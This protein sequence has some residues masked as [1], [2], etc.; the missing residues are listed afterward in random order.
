MHPLEQ[1]IYRIIVDQKLFDRD[2]RLVVG[3]SGGPDSMALLYL[4]DALR[5][6][7]PCFPVAVYVDHGLRPGETPAESQVV[8]QAAGI[9]DLP[10]EAVCVDTEK[11]ARERGL[12]LEHAARELRYESLAEVADRYRA[13]C[14]V[15]AHT[16][17][18]QVEEVLIRLLRGSG[19]CGLSGMRMRR[20]RIIRPL[21]MTPKAELLHYLQDRN[22]SFCQDSSNLDRRF[23]RNRIRLDLLPLLERE[24]D[25]GVRKALLKTAEN[26]AEDEAFLDGQTESVWQQLVRRADPVQDDGEPGYLLERSGFCLLHSALQRRLAE[27]LL[28][29]LGARPRYEHI[30]MVLTA[31]RQGVTGSELHL[32]Q[33]LRVEVKRDLLVFSY[34]RGRG[35]WRGR[36]SS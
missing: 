21:L 34:P 30:I 28:W 32:S 7:F 15:V 18:D 22:I 31:A 14:L 8:E 1:K 23:L 11:C 6:F 29:E 4:L 35:S 13:S 19:R 26:L 2:D 33:G 20:G 25:P 17:D 3:V 24:Y 12:S 9:L 16:A 10:F 27:R 36:L 5:R